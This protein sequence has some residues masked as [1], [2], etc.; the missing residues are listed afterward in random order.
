M[1][2]IFFVYGLIALFFSAPVWAGGDVRL[3]ASLKLQ[4]ALVVTAKMEIALLLLSQK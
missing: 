1:K 2:R 4:A 3:Q